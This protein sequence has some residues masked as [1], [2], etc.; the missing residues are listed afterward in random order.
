MNV[1]AY[2]EFHQYTTD[3][4]A[5]LSWDPIGRA[6]IPF[7][8][9][10]RHEHSTWARTNYSRPEL[11][12]QPQSIEELRLVVELARRCRK[13]IVV[14][15]SGHSPS[16][17]TCTSSWMINLD[18][19]GAVVAEDPEKLLIVVQAGIRLYQFIS[20]LDKRGWA[21]PNLGSITEQ[22]IA[23]AIATSTHGSSLR[24][25]LIS[26][27]VVSLTVM[28]S[29]GKLVECSKD[30]NK[31]LFKAGLVSLGGLGIIVHV[32]FQA[33][34][35]FKVRWEQEVVGLPQILKSWDDIWCQ[36]EFVRCWWFPYSAR[37]I[38]WAG[39]KSKDVLREPPK[40]WYGASFGRW[41]YEL[42]L[43]VASWLP[44]IMPKVEQYVFSMQYGRGEG[45][46]GSAVQPSHEALTMDCLFPQLVNEVS[47]P[48]LALAPPSPCR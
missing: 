38:L 45:A 37:T 1:D 20:E 2:K 44:K 6:H 34:P 29:N 27:S 3:A 42:L 10:L 30:K 19:F 32:G 46:K 22:S 26:E 40:S 17:I 5:A 25:G 47:S 14:V 39:D 8:A 24:H 11:Y 18:N 16:D 43:Y 41:S 15:G 28:L 33:V 35:D 7:R 48:C 21:M 23:G 9:S 13:Q 4:I 12:I 31:D 36:S